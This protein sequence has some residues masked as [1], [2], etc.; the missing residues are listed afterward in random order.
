MTAAAAAPGGMPV[1]VSAP[2]T[3]PSTPPIPPGS[4]TSRP[5][6]CPAAYANSTPRQG[7]GSPASPKQAVSTPASASRP[8]PVQA[9]T[10]AAEPSPARG[11]DKPDMA[12]ASRAMARERWGRR[13]SHRLSAW[14]R[15]AATKSPAVPPASSTAAPASSGREPTPATAAP[16]SNRASVTTVEV[17]PPASTAHTPRPVPAPRRRYSRTCQAPPVTCPAG[18]TLA[19]PVEASTRPNTVRHRNRAP[20]P[21]NWRCTAVP[22]ASAT[23]WAVTA[24]PSQASRS[25]S[26]WAAAAR[27][28]PAAPGARSAAAAITPAASTQ[29]QAQPRREA[30]RAG[31]VVMI[32]AESSP[33]SGGAPRPGTHLA[34]GRRVQPDGGRA[35][36]PIDGHPHP[37]GH[38]GQ[39]HAASPAREGDRR[40]DGGQHAQAR[41]GDPAHRIQQEVVGRGQYHQGGGGRIEPGEVAPPAAGSGD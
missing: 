14:A 37:S 16:A 18:I 1:R 13:L 27:T 28:S 24:T 35:R 9:S 23:P 12:P 29:A 34:A 40:P 41:D 4:G 11:R 32:P 25:P 3:P 39:D 36:Q 17:T 20:A 10:R 7:I 8:M 22:L 30:G 19:T 21:S 38:R 26:R 2:R 33:W 31:L 6:I 15:C 5:A